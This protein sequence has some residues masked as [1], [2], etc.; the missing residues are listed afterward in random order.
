MHK[1]QKVNRKATFL[2]S[3]WRGG[4][5]PLQIAFTRILLHFALDYVTLI[6]S[7]YCQIVFSA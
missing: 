5:F 4:C 1:S 7:E 2:M 3:H 6:S